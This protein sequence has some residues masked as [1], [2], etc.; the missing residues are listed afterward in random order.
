MS[1][2]AEDREMMETR[3]SGRGKSYRMGIL[4]MERTM[5]FRMPSDVIDLPNG[6]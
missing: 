1:Q 6:N 2:R 4:P 5:C 3:E